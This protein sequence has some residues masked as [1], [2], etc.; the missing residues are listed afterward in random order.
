MTT[1]QVRIDEETKNSAK[2]VLDKVGMDIS[3]AIKIYLKQIVIYKGIPFKVL[4][5][6][7]LTPEEEKE[8]LKAE[9][10]ALR[11]ENIVAITN[12]WK[13]TKAFL[14]SLKKKPNANR[15]PQKFRKKVQKTFRKNK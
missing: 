7:G 5:E 9:A 10:E 14:D 1:I 12:N 8:I 6:K 11:G 4:T 3:S 15:I 2:K 13:E